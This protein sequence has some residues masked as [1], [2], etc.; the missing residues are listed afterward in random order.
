MVE[1]N[2]P[3]PANLCSGGVAKQ[4][5]WPQAAWPSS[6]RQPAGNDPP[7][8]VAKAA[9]RQLIRFPVDPFG[10]PETASPKNP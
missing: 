4:A 1:P 7:G 9:S 3:S 8:N 5:K 6:S 2:L 10:I